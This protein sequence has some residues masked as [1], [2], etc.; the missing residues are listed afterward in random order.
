[1]SAIVDSVFDNDWDG[2]N[3]GREKK[4]NIEQF[5]Y[6]FDSDFQWLIGKIQ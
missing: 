5:M 2:E 3:I 1:M 6:I 4:W